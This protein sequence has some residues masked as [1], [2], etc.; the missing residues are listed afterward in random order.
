MCGW[1]EDAVTL[2]T[3]AVRDTLRGKSADALFLASTSFPFMDRSNAVLVGEAAGLPATLRTLESA[4]SRRAGTAAL[5]SAIDAVRAKPESSV[6]VAA[7]EHRVAQV[8]ST[9]ELAFG[10]GAAA[11]LM[12]NEGCAADFVDSHSHAVD[13]VDQ[14]RTEG[15]RGV[16]AWEERW[17]RDEGYTRIV[18]AAIQVFLQRIGVAAR[19]IRHVILPGGAASAIAKKIGFDSDAVLDSLHASVGDTG[20]AHPLLLLNQALGR[21]RPDELILVTSFGQGCDVLL[22]RA[23]PL[24]DARRSEFGIAKWLERRIPETNY[25]KFQSFNGVVDRDFGKRAEADR[26]TR[27]SA[28]ER[29]RDLLT[30]FKA[31]VCMKCGA[32]QVPKGRYCVNPTCGASEGFT[33]RSLTGSFGTVTSWTADRLTFDRDPPAYFGNVEFDCGGR[34]LMDFTDVE[35]GR[36][37]VG[38]RVSFHFRIK[39][40]DEQRKFRRYFWKAAPL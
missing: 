5:L 18:P 17:I 20:A 11:V 8:G 13:F 35:A 19:D 26:Q 6:V 15:Q 14:Y 4:G 16:Y 3:E 33:E 10:D 28:F 27:L 9:Q 24:I 31:T 29:N 34:M 32:V 21:A 2:A 39:E 37:D 7:A 36:L 23:T 22:F 25:S 30:A 1:D 12:A 38:A 40:L